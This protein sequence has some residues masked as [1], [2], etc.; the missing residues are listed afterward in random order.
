MSALNTL[1]LYSTVKAWKKE[2]LIS[3]ID[4][5]IMLAE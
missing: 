1:I 2:Y 3:K 4:L 5:L